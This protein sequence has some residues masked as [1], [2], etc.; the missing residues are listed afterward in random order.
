M[1]AVVWA[2]EEMVAAERVVAVKLVAGRQA[3]ATLVVSRD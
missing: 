1:V 3:G 2:A